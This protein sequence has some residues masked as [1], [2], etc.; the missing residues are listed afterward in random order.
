M[1]DKIPEGIRSIITA[2]SQQEAERLLKLKVEGYMKSASFLVE[3]MKG[4]LTKKYTILKPPIGQRRRLRI[5]N[6]LE[7]AN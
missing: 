7:R 6:M 5:A 3:L 1:H 4:A 2:P